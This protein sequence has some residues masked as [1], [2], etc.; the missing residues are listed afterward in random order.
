M[1]LTPLSLPPWALE[2]HA[3]VVALI[4]ALV[5]LNP[6]ADSPEG[7]FLALISAAT[8]SFER[9]AFPIEPPTPEEAAAFRAEQDICPHPN[10]ETWLAELAAERA[11]FSRADDWQMRLLTRKLID[12]GEYP[13]EWNGKPIDVWSRVQGWGA[14]WHRYREPLECAK[15]KADLRDQVWGP[16]G[17]REVGESSFKHDCLV[18]YQC[19][20][21]GFRWSP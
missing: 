10:A 11:K 7:R 15:C 13:E 8:D 4:E 18:A 1:A 19:P 12:C 3:R 5:E 2:Y 9:E 6:A 20:D 16:P 14:Y 21:C 17:K